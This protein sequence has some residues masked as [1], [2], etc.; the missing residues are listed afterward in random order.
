MNSQKQ[1]PIATLISRAR[2]F[3]RL[4]YSKALNKPFPLVVTFSLTPQCNFDCAYCYGDY[5]NRKREKNPI[6]TEQALAAIEEL[7]R[8]GMSFLQLSG[9]EP[10]LREDIDRIVDKANA[11]G[12]TL[13]ISTNGSLVE[14]KI[15]TVKKIK[16]ICISWDGNKPSNDSNR[17]SGTFET[18][19]KAIKAAKKA[20]VNV[21]TYTTV[22]RNNLAALDGILEFAKRFHIYTEF[23]FFVQRSLKSDADYQNL[24]ISVDEY[25]EAV[26]KLIAYKKRGYPILFSETVMR[27]ILN[28]PDYTRKVILS[29]NPPEFEYI[30][31]F[32]GRHM[33]FI[34]CDGKV[35]PC[36]QFIGK[37][38]GWDF[39]ETGMRKAVRHSLDH[40][41]KACYLMCVNDLNLMFS[42]TPS[43]LRNYFKITVDE[44]LKSK[45]FDPA[46]FDA[47]VAEYLSPR[48]VSPMSIEGCP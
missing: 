20:G 42:L 29:K 25:R 4:L 6:T 23:G 15:E 44:G 5:K 3:S 24:D 26:K 10:L 38:D 39:R 13:G 31:C 36:I 30:K 21:H 45:K 16:T 43:V 17:G 28:W 1:A 19:M 22:N 47:Y 48:G 37:F 46:E 40:G 34:D 9:G 8:M 18:I 32:G 33:I 7:A 12:I 14:K 27:K 35:Y 11:L 2:F 41:C